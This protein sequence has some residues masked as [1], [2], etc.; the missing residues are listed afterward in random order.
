MD[1]TLLPAA[2]RRAGLRRGGRVSTGVPVDAH[3]L[4][5]EP[6]RL[7]PDV[8]AAG[9]IVVTVHAEA[10]RH[11]HRTLQELTA[12]S[13]AQPRPVI[14]G[15]AINP[16]TPVQAIEPVLDLVDLVLVLAVN[17]GWPGQAP[18]AN[19]ARRVAAVREPRRRGPASRSWSASTAASPSRTP[20]RSPAGAPTSSSAAAR[21]STAV[22]RPATSA[23][24]SSRCGHA[25][26]TGSASAAPAVRWNPSPAQEEEHDQR[27]RQADRHAAHAH[28]DHPDRRRGPRHR[29]RTQGL[30]REPRLGPVERLRL[31]AAAAARHDGPRRAGRVP[32][33]RRRDHGRR[34]RLRAHPAGQRPEHLPGV[35]RHPR[36]GRAA[37]RVHEAHR[38]GQRAA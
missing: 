22:T 38:G 2:H 17:P 19:T 27:K 3:L 6:R 28:D 14:R 1:G 5:D 12:L 15:Y 16:G 25:A 24:C 9:A 13:A 31:Q 4:V 35:P 33:D 29:G 37:H 21:S 11:P 8:V 18:A 23:A 36:R 30:H 34:P 10:T 20:P 7:L 26:P 32:D